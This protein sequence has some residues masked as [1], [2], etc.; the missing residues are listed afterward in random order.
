M[1]SYRNYT[2]NVSAVA[3]NLE[4]LSSGYKINRAGDDAAGLAI[5]QK[6]RL[7]IAGLQQA[8]NNAK[9]G[10][11]LVQTAEGALTEVHDML[12]RMYTLAEQSANGTYDND[13]DRVQLQKEVDQLRTEI[14]RIADSA[15]F[16]GIKLLDG[17]L[18]VK[19]TAVDPVAVAGTEKQDLVVTAEGA[20]A[21]DH[22]AK[23]AG[24]TTGDLSPATL[25]EDKFDAV[26][27]TYTNGEGVEK[28]LTLGSRVGNGA[29]GT[30]DKAGEELAED[31]TDGTLSVST[32]DSNA[33]A[34]LEEF[35]QTFNVTG[36]GKKLTISAKDPNS[37]AAVTKFEFA[38]DDDLDAALTALAEPSGSKTTK[39]AGPYV[40]VKVTAAANVDASITINGNKFSVSE[41]AKT[42]DAA[43][44]AKD[45]YSQ[46]KDAGYDVE[47]VA[48]TEGGAKDTVRIK[49]AAEA[50]KGVQ[51]V[52]GDNDKWDV[53]FSAS[54]KGKV[55]FTIDPKTAAGNAAA[56]TP[57]DYTINYVDANGEEKSKTLTIKAGT[58]D[59][60]NL[61]DALK[62]AINGDSELGELFTADNASGTITIES[63]ASGTA[64]GYITGLSSDDLKVANNMVTIEAPKDTGKELRLQ[65]KEDD[66]AATGNDPSKINTF[67]NGDKITIDGKT[68][69]FMSDTGMSVEDGVVKVGIDTDATQTWKNLQKALKANGVES[70]LTDDKAG[71]RFVDKPTE[72][73]TEKTGGLRL[74]IGD[75]AEEFNML[76]VSVSDMHTNAMKY[77]AA[78]DATGYLKDADG[79]TLADIDISTQ[80]GAAKAMAVIKNATNYVSDMR[81]T[82]GATQNRLDHTINNLSVM[83][84]NIQDAESTIRD[85]DVAAEMMEYTKNN[86]LVQS[87][88]AMLAQAN[89]LPQGVLQLLG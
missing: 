35:L 24:Y 7:Q 87:A 42:G 63:K 21:V 18:D 65:F 81:G 83:Q 66:D 12:E 38:E 16:N 69:Q 8:Q 45:L 50:Q 36:D 27:I 71:L 3:K 82:L 74:Q 15:N 55:T 4:K 28:V 22:L 51:I 77:T 85:V 53:N 44:H 64:S 59:A 25:E 76:T 79:M 43:A 5:S 48:S 62:N 88:Q 47:L 73:V 29:A 30:T 1:S 33:K 72:T 84:E 89:Q 49:E 32:S 75:T 14:N 13:T 37:T 70:T 9:S 58:A 78:E 31:I 46:L 6:M 11:N 19:E 52:N 34:D 86:I 40:D 20:M 39:A 41:D 2:N 56:D 26:R 67:T 61:G 60:A 68:Y 23:G 57:Y 10:I 17:S 80:D 54:T